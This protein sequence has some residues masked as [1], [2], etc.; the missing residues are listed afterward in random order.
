LETA[1]LAWQLYTKAQAYL[2]EGDTKNAHKFYDLTIKPLKLCGS[3]LKE[4][5]IESEKKLS[6]LEIS[7]GEA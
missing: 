2:D 7:L 1:S 5:N 6:R 3:A 4:L